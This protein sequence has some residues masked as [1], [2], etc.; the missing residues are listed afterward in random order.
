MRKELY[1]IVILLCVAALGCGCSE[2][3]T[4]VAEREEAI[5]FGLSTKAGEM[6]RAVTDR[7]YARLF[8]AERLSEHENKPGTD[9]EALHCGLEHRYELQGSRFA[10]SGLLG[11]WYKFAFVCVPALGGDPAL[12]KALFEAFDPKE[13]ATE[14]D[15]NRLMVNYEPVLRYQQD[16]QTAATEDLAIYRRVIDRWVDPANPTTEDVVMTRLTGELVIDLGIPVDQFEHPVREVLLHVPGMLKRIYIRDRS[17]EE[18][19]PDETAMLSDCSFTYTVAEDAQAARQTIRLSLLP[20]ELT[21]A[22]LVVRFADPAVSSERFELR[23]S[24]YQPIEIRKNVRTT[25]LFN[26]YKKDWFEVRYAG[27]DGQADIDVDKDDWDG[28]N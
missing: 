19:I 9:V 11:Q 14:H 17:N 3:E 4:A 26:G 2:E 27:F 24:S 5:A 18:V 16:K 8:V 10:L 13:N 7:Q 25:V 23:N 21:D 28:W 15:F 6:T 1:Y 20:Q 12:G 22:E